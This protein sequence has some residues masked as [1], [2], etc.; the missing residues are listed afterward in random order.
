MEQ[1]GTFTPSPTT[2]LAPARFTAF[3]PTEPSTWSVPPVDSATASSA[4]WPTTPFNGTFYAAVLDDQDNTT[5]DSIDS[6]G[7][8][9]ALGQSLGTDF[10]GLA[11]DISEWLVLRHRE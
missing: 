2:S 10:T 7:I 9:T 6:S 1:T 8:A 4:V 3:S 11:F 5:L